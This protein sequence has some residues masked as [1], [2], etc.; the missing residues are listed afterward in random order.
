L[1]EGLAQ[2]LGWKHVS[3]GEFVRQWYKEHNI[4]LEE[5]DKIPEEVD[6]N[7]DMGLKKMM[8]EKIG[9]VFESHLGGF[10][11]K[12]LPKTFKVLCRADDKVRMERA[13]KRDGVSIEEAKKVSEK[14]STT[15]YDKFNRL[16]G[17]ENVFDPKYFNLIVDT[18]KMSKEDVL[19]EVINKLT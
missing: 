5:A 11:A 7:L 8:G 17:V 16:Y 15:L 12:D 2:A 4:P 3:S 6:R 14:R 1:A 18:T 10:L 9:I 19:Q 13:A